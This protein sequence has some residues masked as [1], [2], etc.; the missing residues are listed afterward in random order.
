MV[1]TCRPTARYNTIKKQS[2]IAGVVKLLCERSNIAFDDKQVDAR[3]KKSVLGNGRASKQDIC[4]FF[5]VEDDNEGD[6][7]LMLT[8]AL[9]TKT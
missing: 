8:F 3:V 4:D 5:K 6:A 9:K 7:L 2:E 1:F